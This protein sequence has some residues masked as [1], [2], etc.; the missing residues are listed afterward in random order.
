MTDEQIDKLA[1]EGCD[2]WETEDREECGCSAVEALPRLLEE[3][4]RLKD[5]V[6][7]YCNGL[8]DADE[9]R[10]ALAFAEQEAP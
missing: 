3:R 7:G 6:R 9:G 2:C 8:D 10:A 1:R 5:F 4:K